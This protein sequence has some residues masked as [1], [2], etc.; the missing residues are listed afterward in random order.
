MPHIA[1][2]LAAP[3]QEVQRCHPLVGAEPRLT[4]EVVQ[5]GHHPLH[6]VPEPR[7]LALRV[8][9]DRVGRDIVYGQVEERR[10]ACQG[11]HCVLVVG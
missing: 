6:E 2:D 7:F 4:R 5:V 11:C 8:D 3:N 1:A 10:A 9:P